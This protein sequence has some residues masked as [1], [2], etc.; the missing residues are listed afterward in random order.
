[1]QRSSR[2]VVLYIA[3]SIDGKIACADGSIA[4][5]ENL[6][7]DCGYNEWIKSIGT[8]L[9]GRTTYE[10]VVTFP[11]EYS[12][13][14]QKNYIFSTTKSTFEH[15]IAVNP[16]R[17]DDFV[18]QLKTDASS[19]KDIWLIGG[20]KLIENFIV[21]D[22]IDGYIITIIPIILGDGIPMFTSSIF[23]SYKK[24]FPTKSED[25]SLNQYFRLKESKTFD[26]SLI[27]L[28]YERLRDTSCVERH[29]KE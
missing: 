10:Q 24:H 28:T 23:D 20:G 17:L 29:K 27:M 14:Q 26:E 8:V 1:M 5:L 12:Y 15:G 2:K 7:V 11:G 16:Q 3:S 22:L 18:H 21:N 9:L 6:S 25:K 19:E 4:W 13:K